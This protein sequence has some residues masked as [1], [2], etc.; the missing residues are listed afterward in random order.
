MNDISSTT[1][2]DHLVEPGAVPLFD[3]L[4]TIP[5]TG[6]WRDGDFPLLR[7]LPV[8]VRITSLLAVALIA[9]MVFA[10]VSTLGEQAVSKAMAEQEAYRQLGELVGD[11]RAGSLA[12]QTLEQEF[13]RSRRTETAEAHRRAAEQVATDVRALAALPAAAPVAAEMSD[14]AQRLS[15]LAAQFEEVVATEERLGLGED[16][17][18]RGALRRSVKAIEDELKVWPNQESLWNKMLSMRQAEKDFM[19]YGNDEHLGRHRKF[20]MEFDMKID[21]AKLPP[22][23]AEGFRR[24]LGTYTDDMDAFAEASTLLGA[25]AAALRGRIDGIRPAIGALF[26]YARE[27]SLYAVARQNDTRAA[28]LRHNAAAGGLAILV[29]CLMSLVLSRSIVAPL[30]LIEQ[31]M[32]RLVGGETAVQVPATDRRDEIGDMARAVAVF[33]ENALAMVTLQHEHEQLMRSAEAEKRAA[34]TRLADHFEGTVKGVVDSV[35]AGSQTIADTAR[36]MGARTHAHG[37]SRSLAVAEA[38][39]KAQESVMAASEAAEELACSI[40]QVVGLVHESTRIARCGERD[41]DRADQQVAELSLAAK[42]VGMVLG[43]ISQ[44][45]YQTNLLALNATIEA[46]RA[47]SAGRAFAVVAGE[48]KHLA[49]ETANATGKIAGQ[50]SAI[51]QVAAATEDSIG[52]IG[53]TIRR[54]A[55]ITDGVAGAMNRQAEATRRIGDCVRTVR[56]DSRI[57]V[58]GV[59][60]VVQST[61]AYCRSAIRVLWDAND[62]SHPVDTLRGEVDAFLTRVRT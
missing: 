14:L 46:S 25:Q 38:A 24:L 15:D 16:D 7:G 43:L 39:V 62:L 20:S 40:D 12:M 47:G 1:V 19:L 22:S 4:G 35:S 52:A 45:A 31:T 32:R 8:G 30:R 42:E 33:K 37:E 9:A 61:A 56:R 21:A 13:L 27:G 2:A 53:N 10:V 18:L 3:R 58:G 26:A 55:E 23:T 6:A 5:W 17:G 50:I 51:Q 29:F 49:I 59:V 54:M 36:R 44:I 11:V 41:L 34:V 28:I 48:V 57:V 60:E